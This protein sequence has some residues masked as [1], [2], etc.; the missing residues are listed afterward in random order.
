[1]SAPVPG[2]VFF[3]ENN[4]WEE[5][6]GGIS[7]QFIGYNSRI[8]MVKVKFEKGA[9]GAL[10]HHFH[11]QATYVASGI[12]RIAGN[13]EEKELKATGFLFRPMWNMELSAWNQVC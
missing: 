12:F 11:I 4:R 13:G 6:S 3:E 8:M 7:R 2:N 1:M 5:V 10:H 9:V